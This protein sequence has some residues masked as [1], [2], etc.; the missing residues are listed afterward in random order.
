MF[1]RF[2]PDTKKSSTIDQEK[3][4][5]KNQNRDFAFGSVRE[6]FYNFKY[7]KRYNGDEAKNILDMISKNVKAEQI[8]ADIV[9][10]E[11]ESKSKKSD[12]LPNIKDPVVEEEK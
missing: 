9:K 3:T 7:F 5:K 12:K 10:K 6:S 8:H 11:F 2:E 1:K 4:T